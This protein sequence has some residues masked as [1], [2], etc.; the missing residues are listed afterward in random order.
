MTRLEAHRR[1]ARRLS[2]SW[3]VPCRPWGAVSCDWKT[4]E[5]WSRDEEGS[6]SRSNCK[7]RTL[8]LSTTLKTRRRTKSQRDVPVTHVPMVSLFC[9]FLWH[10]LLVEV[11]WLLLYRPSARTILDIIVVCHNRCTSSPIYRYWRVFL[12]TVG[13]NNVKS[14]GLFGI[15]VGGWW[16]WMGYFFLKTIFYLLFTL[17]VM[18][19]GQKSL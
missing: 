18:S 19:G 14:L 11:S 10:P 4:T 2:S 16:V 17:P 8:R 7:R 9:P 13:V 6:R 15:R 1:L 5:H 3:V 12:P